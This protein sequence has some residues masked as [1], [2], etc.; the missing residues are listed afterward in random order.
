MT[1]FLKA[2]FQTG[3][4]MKVLIRSF[5][6]SITDGLPLPIPY[7]EILR[8]SRIM[9]EIFSQLSSAQNAMRAGHSRNVPVERW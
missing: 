6:R 5:Y 3:Y 1:K 8:T 9:D 7:K 2:D 4:S